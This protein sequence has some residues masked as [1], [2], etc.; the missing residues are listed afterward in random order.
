MNNTPRTVG[1]K[2]EDLW[3]AYPGPQ[4]DI[5]DHDVDEDVRDDDKIPR[6]NNQEQHGVYHVPFQHLSQH[7]HQVQPQL[8]QQGHHQE[9]SL[10]RFDGSGVRRAPSFAERIQHADNRPNV[11]S[12][13]IFYC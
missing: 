10:P 12:N 2:K 13:T 11:Y 7:Q 5:A 3:M 1:G 9:G 4:E 6:H 8:H